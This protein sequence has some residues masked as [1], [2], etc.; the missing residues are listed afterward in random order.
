MN[1]L[2]LGNHPAIDFLNTE[3]SP[4]GKTVETIGDGRAFLDWLVGAG[5]LEEAVAARYLR[6]FGVKALDST[7]AEARRVREWARS[8]D[9]PLACGAACRLRQG[10]RSSEQA[11]GARGEPPR[12][13]PNRER[14]QH[15]RAWSNRDCGRVARFDRPEHRCIDHAGGSLVGQTL[16][17]LRLHVVVP[18][19]DQRTSTDVLQLDGLRKSRQGCRVPRARAGIT[20]PERR[21]RR[22]GVRL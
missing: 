21:S 7:A 22:R 16:R 8:L 3:F 4:D 12:S 5:L 10:N 14:P 20:N 11:A 2:F 19:S 18:G 9:R 15:R 1:P 6:R 13:R 17:R